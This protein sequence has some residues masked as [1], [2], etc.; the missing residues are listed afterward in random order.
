MGTKG[1]KNSSSIE[2][3]R[4]Q[5]EDWRSGRVRK[6]PIPA[7]L[8]SA[9]IDAARQEG[10][11]RTAQQLH[12]DAGKLKRLVVAADGGE[13]RARRKPRFVELIASA[14]ASTPSA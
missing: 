3:V 5:L 13:R 11:N 12:L 14:P 10:V 7:A 1:G 4:T 8:W 2:A 6:S 9:A